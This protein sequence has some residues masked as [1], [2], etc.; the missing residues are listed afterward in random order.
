MTKRCLLPVLL[1]T[2]LL[3]ALTAPSAMAVV[4][5]T[6]TILT[7]ADGTLVTYHNTT[8]S[9]TI[10]VSGSTTGIVTAVDIRCYYQPNQ[11]SPLANNVPLDGGGNFSV[12]DVNLSPI[13]G[14][15][16]WLVAVPTGTNP[17]IPGPDF[18]GVRVTVNEYGEFLSAGRAY[19]FFDFAGQ[20]NGSWGYDST[21]DCG[22]SWGQ[23]NDPAFNYASAYTFNCNQL[24]HDYK[25]TS[26]S[27]PIAGLQVNGLNAYGPYHFSAAGAGSGGGSPTLTHSIT[28]DP[29]TRDAT[30]VST[31][32]FSTCPAN[33]IDPGSSNCATATDTGVS[34]SRRIEQ[35]HAGLMSRVIDVYKNNTGAPVTL[36]IAYE[37][38]HYF[39]VTN[40][41]DHIAYAFPNGTTVTDGTQFTQVNG[42]F[43]SPSTILISDPTKPDGDVT[44]GRGALT[45]FPG[46]DSAVFDNKNTYFLQYSNKVVPAGGTY[47]IEGAFSQ[48]F[49]QAQLNGLVAEAS[50]IVTPQPAFGAQAKS[51]LK[52]DKKKTHIAYVSGQSV[53]CPATGQ[54]C[55]ITGALTTK[56]KL[57]AK[58]RKKGSKK[59]P[60]A[61]Y[62]TYTI[63][64]FSA[65]G[66]PGSVTPLNIKLG[67]TAVKLFKQYGKLNTTFVV[68]VSAGQYA[69][70]SST[71]VAKL[72]S[73]KFPKPKKKKKH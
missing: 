16:C 1:L 19:D 51:S 64:K 46:A 22:I 69:S 65:T 59:K 34:L 70:A 49:G 28:V 68:N 38:D 2:M 58:K 56:V 30:I 40:D 66:A 7:P 15:N 23:L 63:G 5:P 73:P 18:H 10:S 60:K 50:R 9:G 39:G 71:F 36:N 62:K 41:A 8:H 45:M 54:A 33:A 48:S 24:L 53:L 6:T 72:K 26:A 4:P 17:T 37:Q 61:K 35:N 43:A 44:V 67:I 14:S 57:P 27:T 42:P 13:R 20:A 11:A 47:R 31:E 29:V 21:A 32:G 3:A 52:L 25:P 55:A 12:T